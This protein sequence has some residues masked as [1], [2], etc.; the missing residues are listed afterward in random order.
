M[1]EVSQMVVVSRNSVIVNHL[2]ALKKVAEEV[3]V[4]AVIV[5]AVEVVEAAA[6]IAVVE[7]VVVAAVIVVVEDVVD[8]VAAVV[9]A[10]VEDVEV[11]VV[12][13]NLLTNHLTVQRGKIKRLPLMTKQATNNCKY[14]TIRMISY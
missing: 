1:V 14:R 13:I 8:L 4:V 7:E 12:Q 5:V 3:V 6:V 2:V 11:L 10:V 9:V